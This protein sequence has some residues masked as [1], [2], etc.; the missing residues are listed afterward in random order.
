MAFFSP[1]KVGLYKRAVLRVHGKVCSVKR[2]SG[3][4]TVRKRLLFREGKREGRTEA[5]TRVVRGARFGTHA[6]GA[7]FL[8]RSDMSHS[9]LGC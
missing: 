2:N 7:P 9:V 6:Q 5:H 3:A 8:P 4:E 1:P